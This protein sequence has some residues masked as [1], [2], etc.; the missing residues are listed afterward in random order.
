MDRRRRRH[1]RRRLLARRGVQGR[2]RHAQLGLEGRQRPHQAALRRLLGPGDLRRLEGPDR[3]QE[4]ARDAAHQRLLRSGPEGREHRPAHGDPGVEGRQD[5]HQHPADDRARLGGQEGAGQAA[6]RR[7][8]GE[9]RQRAGDQAGR[10]SDLRGAVAVE[11]GGAWLPGRR[12]RAADRLR[13]G[14]R[15]GP[16]ARDRPHR[17]RHLVRRADRA[18]GERDGRPRLDHGGL[19][20]DRHRRRHRLFAARPDALPF[21]AGRRQVHSRRG[22]R[23]RHQGRAQRG[24]R[25]P[26]RRGRRPRP[27]PDRSELHV[28]RSDLDRPGRPGR[29]GRV[30]LAAAGAAGLPRPEG[31]PA[32]DSA[33]RAQAQDRHERCRRVAG[34]ALEPRRAAAALARGDRGHGGPARAGGARARHAARLPRRRQRPARHDDAPGLRPQHR[35]LRPR[36]ERADR[37]RRRHV[38][39]ER[40]G[41]GRLVRPERARGLRRGLRDEAARSTRPATPP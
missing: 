35:G 16:A 13:L 8:R 38:Q 34:G 5:R 6:D 27:V 28:R 32:A 33:A 31:R 39:S 12:D 21:R 40:Q 30:D 4:P 26:H 7:R 23:V 3:R 25:R 17:A 41:R 29:D 15:G 24:H 14:G 18:A 22:G 1:H 11:P 10:R 37:D 20:P 36:H 19:R 2:L 9:R